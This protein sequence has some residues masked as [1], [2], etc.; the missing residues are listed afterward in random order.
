MHASPEPVPVLAS[1]EP[2]LTPPAPPATVVIGL[3]GTP[4]GEG[5]FLL[6]LFLI[7]VTFIYCSCIVCVMRGTGSMPKYL[8]RACCVQDG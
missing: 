5:W 6:T 7:S 4:Q 8:R 2:G 3:P 1:P